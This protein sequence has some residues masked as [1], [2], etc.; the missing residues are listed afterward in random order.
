MKTSESQKYKLAAQQVY[1]DQVRKPSFISRLNECCASSEDREGTTHFPERFTM[2]PQTPDD[3]SLEQHIE[4]LTK[5][6][7]DNTRSRQNELKMININAKMP[8]EAIT[9]KISITFPASFNCFDNLRE[10]LDITENK[11]NQSGSNFIQK[12]SK[13]L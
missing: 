4:A 10:C 13:V 2:L 9:D 3:M 11:F 8:I 7:S 12:L 1:N 6:Y 5:K